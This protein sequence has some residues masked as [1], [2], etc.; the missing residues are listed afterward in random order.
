ADNH[1]NDVRLFRQLHPRQFF[2]RERVA[3]IHVHPG[4]VVHSVGVRDELNRSEVFAD[5]LGA[6]VEISHVRNGLRDHLAVGPQHQPQHAVSAGVLRAHVHQHFVGADV[7]FDDGR[8]G[9]GGGG[10]GRRRG[11]GGCPFGSPGGRA[12]FG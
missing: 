2:N 8:V 6:A 11:G 1:A 5:L 12:G 9:E 10:G 3:E 7:E 4:Q